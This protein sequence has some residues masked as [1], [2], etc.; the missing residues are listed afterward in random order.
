MVSPQN[1]K[2]LDEW[3]YLNSPQTPH[4]K[5]VGI[6][7][8]FK[9][10]ISKF[11]L[12][13]LSSKTKFQSRQF[14]FLLN[15]KEWSSAKPKFESWKYVVPPSKKQVPNFGHR[16][17]SNPI[18]KVGQHRTL[19]VVHFCLFIKTQIAKLE[20]LASS[21]TRGCFFVLFSGYHVRASFGFEA[22]RPRHKE[23][24]LGVRGVAKTK[25]QRSRNYHCSKD[26]F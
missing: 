7:Y 2:C 19:E 23:K 3:T 15:T 18:L 24:G 20:I 26:I 14:V 13:G 5:I 12:F 21:K 22:V 17:S 1:Q 11:G 16:F 8:L 10:N 6:C 9:T 4:V 25:F